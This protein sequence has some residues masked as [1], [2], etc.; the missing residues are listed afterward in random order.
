[1]F[2]NN[3]SWIEH[4]KVKLNASYTTSF[5]FSKEHNYRGHRPHHKLAVFYKSAMDAPRPNFSY[6]AGIETILVK[7]RTLL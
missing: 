4:N 3:C 5:I 1:M 6:F 2:K 7:R